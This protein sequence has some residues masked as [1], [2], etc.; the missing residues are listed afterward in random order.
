MTQA[1]NNIEERIRSLE[2][3]VWLVVGAGSVLAVWLGVTTFVSI[4]DAVQNALTTKAA[5]QSLAQIESLRENSLA[6]SKKI[7]AILSEAERNLESFRKKIKIKAYKCPIGLNKKEAGKDAS[8]LSI[9]CQGQIS[10]IENCDNL[11]W[12]GPG[13]PL[14]EETR[15]CE[16]IGS[17]YL[18]ESGE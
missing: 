5:K 13:N 9:G 2:N 14:N 3:K 12:H 16:E 1:T 6:N 18:Y 11:S 15:K 7:D 8:W 17:L 10:S 4:P